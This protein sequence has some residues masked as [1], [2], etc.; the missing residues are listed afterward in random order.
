VPVRCTGETNDEDRWRPTTTN[1]HARG[2]PSGKTSPASVA[3]GRGGSIRERGR[4]W[5]GDEN[6]RRGG[7][8]VWWL[9]CSGG[10]GGSV[11]LRRP[12]WERVAPAMVSMSMMI[13]KGDLTHRY[14]SC[15]SRSSIP[16]STSV[17]STIWIT[18]V[19]TLRSHRGWCTA[20]SIAPPRN[21]IL[22]CR[23]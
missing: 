16:W 20:A 21:A 9:A 4:A 13:P 15:Q 10:Q 1:Q 6:V 12:G 5:R 14:F 3:R 19:R 18:L 17:C 11:R 8:S 22:H 7:G 2:Q 23:R